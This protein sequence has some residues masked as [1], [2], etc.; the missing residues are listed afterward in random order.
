M[1]QKALLFGSATL[2]LLAFAGGAFLYNARQSDEAA[3]A[4]DRNL[5]KLVRMHSPSLGKSDARVHIVEFLDPACGTCKAFYPLVK[6][7]MADN[8]DRI[9][10]SL[11]YAPFHERSDVVV[12]MLEAARKQG[13]YWEALE[14]VL[15]SQESWAPNHK[16][17]PQLV[18][19]FLGGIGLNLEQAR[20]DMDAPE[21][22]AILAQDIADARALK[23]TATPEYFVNGRPLPSFGW[24]QLKGLVDAAVAQAYR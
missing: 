7:L 13:K 20:R 1:R 10:L 2:L 17:Q 24:E 6:K 21:I 3:R 12:K 8:P 5:A 4:A 15:A 9:K 16:P 22:A 23:V 14:A 11:R 18:W 19:N